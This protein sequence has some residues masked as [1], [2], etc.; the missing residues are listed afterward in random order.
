MTL[1]GK[2][3]L[4]CFVQQQPFYTAQNIKVLTP[5]VLMS[6]EE[7]LT[8]CSLIR[9]NRFRYTSHGREANK[10]FDELL[11]PHLDE[12]QKSGKR[13]NL[14]EMPCSESVLEEII[15]LNDREWKDFEYKKIFGICN[16]FYN[17]KPYEVE[18]GKL[19]FIGATE[20]NNGVTSWHNLE[21]IQ[22]SSKTGTRKNHD[23][24]EK[25][26]KGGKYITV[27]NNG[28][29]A[30][31]FYQPL[32]FTCS[33]DVN[34]ITTKNIDMNIYIAMFLSTLIELERF[35]WDYGRKW[36]PIR[37]PSSIIKLPVNSNGDPDW[38]FMEDYIKSL[39][40]S[41]NLSST[42]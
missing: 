1:G 4:S 27:S 6:L 7:R 5:K 42:G 37:M 41:R 28:S 20:Y 16:G 32:D 17:K 26:F 33:H 10:T 30:Y 22:E 14:P 12:L 11:V 19:P 23:I 9:H 25:M 40:F 15:D 3:L 8:Y 2:Y 18:G 13:T 35:R 21:S 24:N 36:R 38:Q 29:V 34:P 39:H 31:A